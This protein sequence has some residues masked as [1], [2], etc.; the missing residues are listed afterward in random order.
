[1]ITKIN[2]SKISSYAQQKPKSQV[3][4]SA[5]PSFAGFSGLGEKMVEQM[6]QKKSIKIMDKMKW[7]DGEEG[8]ILLTAL[9]TGIIAP[10]FIAWNPYVKPKKGA[11][12]EEKENLKKTQKYTAMRQPISAAL[13]IAIQLSIL[14]PINRALD[15]IFHKP[16]NSVKLPV[17]LDKSALHDEKYDRRQIEKRLKKDGVKRTKK[18]FETEVERLLKEEQKSQVSAVATK[19]NSTG[20]IRIGERAVGNER[21]ARVVNGV[22]DDYIKAT[23]ALR[24]DSKGMDYYKERAQILVGNETEFREILG[25]LPAEDKE[26]AT[27]I[28]KKLETINNKDVK[29]ILQEIVSLPE[30]ARRSKCSRTLERIGKIKEICGN[31]FSPQKYMTAM[32]EDY[33]VLSDIVE[34]LEKSKI[35]NEGQATKETIKETI[36]KVANILKRDENNLKHTR[37]FHDTE[38]FHTDMRK[39]VKKVC[40]DITKGYKGVMGKR[41][42]AIK[43]ITTILIGLFITTPITCTSLNWVYPRFMD[44]FF[45]NLS[46]KNKAKPAQAKVGG[47]K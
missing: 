22:I 35:E 32:R 40:E 5:T 17:D 2:Q 16:N 20:E 12:E 7:F 41:Y 37:I 23:K 26:I 14:T 30:D 9:G 34:K 27:Y 11:T 3:H 1:M 43:E 47:D 18:E 28:N 33:D 25:N 45:P 31:N 39:V 42:R 29:K 15:A 46:G 38:V 13:Q 21:T 36:G 44:V 10:L 8:R 4:Q 6:A 24:V 19:L